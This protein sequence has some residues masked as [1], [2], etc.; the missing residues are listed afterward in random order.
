MSYPAS[1]S[2]ATSQPKPP[3]AEK[4]FDPWEDKFSSHYSPSSTERANKE[5]LPDSPISRTTEFASVG[6]PER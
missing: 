6:R 4:P 2:E 5:R 3:K 1:K